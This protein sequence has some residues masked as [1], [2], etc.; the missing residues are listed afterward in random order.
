MITE[1]SKIMYVKLFISPYQRFS[2]KAVSY[3][4]K[5]AYGNKKDAI[6]NVKVLIYKQIH[7]LEPIMSHHGELS[8]NVF[9]L[10]LKRL[11]GIKVRLV[12]NEGL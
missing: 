10:H 12:T 9:L 8:E 4:F 5:R 6:E 11:F 3:N 7:L 2:H 1:V